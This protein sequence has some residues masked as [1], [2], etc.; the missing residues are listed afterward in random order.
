MATVLSSSRG[1][2][3]QAAPHALSRR[4]VRLGRRGALQVVATSKFEVSGTT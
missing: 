1:I 3:A 2:A 4:S